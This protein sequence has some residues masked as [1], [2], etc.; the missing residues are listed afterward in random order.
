M[1]GR[2]SGQTLG[3]CFQTEFPETQWLSYVFAY[4]CKAERV[5]TAIFEVDAT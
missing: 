5:T 4:G 2:R 3:T 1:F